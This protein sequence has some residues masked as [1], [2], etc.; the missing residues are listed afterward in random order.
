MQ[1]AHS[2]SPD[3]P[4]A[5][6]GP[7]DNPAMS[8]LDAALGLAL[9]VPVA[10]ALFFRDRALRG[11]DELAARWFAFARRIHL[12]SAAAPVVW[13][14]LLLEKL[15]QTT[16]LRN[17][18]GDGMLGGALRI[19][20]L[21]APLAILPALLGLLAHEVARRLE[22]TELTWREALARAAWTLA[23]A[24]T[25]AAGLVLAMLAL[26]AR[27]SMV[28]MLLVPVAL[29]ATLL[30]LIRSR[31]TVILDPHAVTR[32]ALR[33]RLFALAEA[34]GVKLRQVYVLPMKRMRLA[35]AFAVNGNVVMITDL[36]LARLS[37]AEVDAVMAH[38]IAHLKRGD[39]RKLLFARLGLGVV[40]FLLLTPLGLGWA[41]L[42]LFAGSVAASAV[43]RRIERATD[44]EALRLGADAGSLVSGLAR[45]AR[46]SHVPLRWS[47]WSG[48][49][50]TH[51]SIE[52]RAR[53]L[54]A[55]A[56]LGP[57][58][59][60]QRLA[61][62]GDA[63]DHY[64]LPASVEHGGRLFST[65][66]KHGVMARYGLVMVLL[67]VG[68]PVALFAELRFLGLD[69][70]HLAQLALALVLTPAVILLAVDFI[71]VQPLRGL[72]RPLAERLGL[73]RD[74][75]SRGWTFA[76]VAPH[77]EPRVYEGF[78]NWDVGWLRVGD[79]TIEF[80]AEEAAFVLRAESVLAIERVKGLPG[81]IPSHA[82]LV[83]WLDSRGQPHA[84]RLAPLDGE[85]LHTMGTRAARLT[86]TLEAWRARPHAAADPDAPAPAPPVGEI[87]CTH[88]RQLGR[89]R[90]LIGFALIDLL[91]A[92]FVGT[93][94]GLPSAWPGAP[95]WLEAVGVALATQLF[96]MIPALRYRE[97]PAPRRSV[98]PAPERRA[99]A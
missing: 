89:P 54:A 10:L 17:E 24:V 31:R 43:S 6:A 45:L 49:F 40:P 37:R 48:F 64:E 96:L 26:R 56:G 63:G 50:L 95:G 3:G 69:V 91:A 66:F 18:F 4:Q 62:T 41:S 25:P 80:A 97:A 39:P 92:G 5:R 90:A 13:I 75:E 53:D 7:A 86:A 84:L 46:L 55:A 1:F 27:M 58:E 52:E 14:L 88:P 68:V 85:A 19:V 61:A 16:F 99:A 44:R 73:G 51:P 74:P 33:D 8:L 47:R 98:V 23:A 67:A 93:L 87:T 34:A 35:N 65:K 38:E 11:R 83:R 59:V 2:G 78:A 9:V 72:R 20:L 70:P 12:L 79:D 22:T 94:L 29:L 57:E 82:V 42:A 28:A 32:G 76:G 60:A 30:C 77:A 71:A 15:R 21:F 36:L 81:W